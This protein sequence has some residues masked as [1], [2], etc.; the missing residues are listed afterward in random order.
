MAVVFLDL[1]RFKVINDG[2]GHAA[3]DRLL[4]EVARRLAA[5]LRSGDTLARFGGDEFTVLLEGVG[6]AA[7]AT[8]VAER[9]LARLGDP[10]QL[11][12][13]EA[14]IGGSVGIALGEP[15]RD[16]PGDLLRQADIALY[17]AKAAGRGTLAVFEPGMDTAARNRLGLEAELRRALEREELT[18]HYQPAVALATG[19]IVGLEALVRWRHPERG[20]LP[21]G[22]F[23]PL[24]EET[25][26][27]VPLGRWALAEA[28]RQAATWP[29]PEGGPPVVVAVNLAPREL[30][31]PGLAA[32]VARALAESGLDPARLELELTEQAL[33]AGEEV[34]EALTALK[35]LGV[36]LA[37]DDFGVGYSSLAYLRRLPVDALK[38]DRAFVAELGCDEGAGRIVRAV[39]GL[40]RGLGLTVT[41]E[42]IETA[43]QLGH[44]RAAG[45]ERGQGYFFAPPLPP[46]EVE[47]LLAEPAPFC[48]TSPLVP[49]PVRRRAG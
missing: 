17:R 13:Q 7:V 31:E 41:A 4:T 33:V 19:R 45:V 18:L 9:L 25:G 30:R 15:G 24:A 34:A 32:A 12:E 47:E 22:E 26:L 38:V 11:E 29:T 48:P 40:A 37:L 49:V 2:L 20:L 8:A 46:D 14:V 16:E 28:C 35:R 3:G 23:L 39:A 36:R 6:S 1:D 10:F 43:E 44:V 42:G 5:C 27:I 21:P